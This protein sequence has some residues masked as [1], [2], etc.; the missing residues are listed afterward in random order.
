MQLQ[1]QLQQLLVPLGAVTAV[2]LRVEALDGA[3]LS[4]GVAAEAERL[5][6]RGVTVAS[7]SAPPS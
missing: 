4:W 6:P 3:A 5:P 2:A 7:E 1:L